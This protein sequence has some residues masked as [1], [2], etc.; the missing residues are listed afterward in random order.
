MRAVQ[1]LVDEFA[2]SSLYAL[3]AVGFTLIGL[4]PLILG[5]LSKAIERLRQATS[6]TL[7]LAEQNVTFALP[8][9]DRVYVKSELSN[10]RQQPRRIASVAAIR[11]GG[12]L[13]PPLPRGAPAPG[14]PGREFFHRAPLILAVGKTPE[15]SIFRQY[16]Q[17]MVNP[18][19]IPARPAGTFGGRSNNSLAVWS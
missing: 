19:E 18:L 10:P 2:I 1:I 11:A 3:A 13:A 6:L 12:A 16:R 5:Q 17:A 9:S 8:H 7:L 14:A 4:A 15:P